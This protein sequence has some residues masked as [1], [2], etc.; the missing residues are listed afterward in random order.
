MLQCAK[1][2]AMSAYLIVNYDVDNPELYTEYQGGAGSALRIGVECEVLVLDPES[3]QLEGEGAGQQT[4]VLKF[5]SLEKAKEIYNSGEYQA[6]VGKR[7]AATSNH[8][9]VLVNGFG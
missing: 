4:V 7:H 6:I 9:A 1:L 2:A 5:V 3:E 8:F